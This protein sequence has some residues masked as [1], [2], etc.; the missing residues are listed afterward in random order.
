MK[1]ALIALLLCLHYPAVYGQ[2]QVID[3]LRQ[4]LANTHVDTSRVLLL[5]QLCEL[6]TDSNLDS[7]FSYGS[8]ALVLAQRIRFPYGEAKSLQRLGRVV[9]IQGDFP[10]AL[11]M[12]MS[13]LKK[14][15]EQRAVGEMAACFFT[16]GTI[17]LDMKDYAKGI[18]YV[19]KANSLFAS[20]GNRKQEMSTLLN[21]SVACRLNK[22]LDT[23]LIVMQHVFPRIMATGSDGDKGFLFLEWGSL[24]FDLGNHQTGLAYEKKAIGIFRQSSNLRR[25]SAIYNNMANFFEQL[26]QPDSAIDY[27][28]QALTAAQ[29]L[30]FKREILG[31]SQ[32]LA[33]LYEPKDPAK[34]LHYLKIATATNNDLFGA[35]TVQS[36]QKVILVEQERQRQA[37]AYQNRLKQYMLLTGLV[38]FLGVAL[39]LYRN[40][41]QKQ[42]ANQVLAQTLSNLRSTQQQLIQREKMASLGELTAGIAHE[43]QNPLNFVNN[44]SDVSVEL[45]EELKEEVQAGRT[46]DVLAL[47]DDLAQNLQRITQ[48]GQRASNIV[49]GMLEHSRSSTGERQSTSLNALAEEYL[50]LAYQG[51]RTKDNS[52][53]CH[54]ETHFAA[55]LPLV[56]VVAS[57]LSRVLLNLY[58]NAFYA[59]SRKAQGQLVMTDDDEAYQPMIWVSTRQVAGEVGRRAVELR[60]RDNGV[61]IPDTI[62]EKIFQ[63]FFT[64]KPTGEGT[65]L[66]LSL[67]YDIVTKGH[68]GTLAV[69]SVEEEFTEFII[70]L[71]LSN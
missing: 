27:A 52:F 47:A 69:A 20:V 23:A 33:K 42:Q 64:T 45:V 66:G 36:L 48:N 46:N 41:R 70:T 40:N 15:E 55:D 26:H 13:A 37:E 28:Q 43:I 14:A 65:G 1:S 50:R 67:S 10:K 19:R 62:K 60:V 17:Y 11:A 3:S 31:A 49:R 35:T 51:M 7:A 71:P 63:P 54:L 30:G 68:G 6:N 21:I 56:E 32:R 34:A 57:D 59:L 61:G 53:T 16:I 44:F 22:R 38:V 24:Q 8:Q 4:R 5:A 39:T 29:T 12:Q 58:N 9:R 25:L 2:K 18:T